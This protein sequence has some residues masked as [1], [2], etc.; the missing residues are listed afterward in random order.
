MANIGPTELIIIAVILLGGLTVLGVGI[1]VAWLI[2]RSVRRPRPE[3]D[4]WSPPP[5]ENPRRPGP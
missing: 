1:L 3:Q 2:I 4:L 5:P